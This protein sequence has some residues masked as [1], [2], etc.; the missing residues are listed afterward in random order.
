MIHK[1]H[2]E[3]T[4]TF[5]RIYKSKVFLILLDFSKVYKFD[6]MYVVSTMLDIEIYNQF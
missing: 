5:I 2:F 4:I 6:D 3:T 1:I